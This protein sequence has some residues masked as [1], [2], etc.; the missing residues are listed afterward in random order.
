MPPRRGRLKT[1]ELIAWSEMHQKCCNPKHLQYKNYGAKGIRV[2]D[3]WQSFDTFVSDMGLRLSDK[4]LA[5]KDI[6]KG[7]NP[8]NCV[9][10]NRG[11]YIGCRTP[12]PIMELDGK[13]KTLAEWCKK[14]KVSENVVRGR[15]YLNW[16]L[17]L[18]LRTPVG[19][20]ERRTL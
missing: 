1:Y 13:Q 20:Y 19:K 7:F 3:R 14:Y 11:E 16:T 15:L 18:A 2:C 10:A 5:R 12:A 8:E 9:W 4:V 17:D 6:T